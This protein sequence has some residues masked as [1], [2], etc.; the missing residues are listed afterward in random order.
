[1]IG[2]LTDIPGFQDVIVS[3]ALESHN[4]GIALEPVELWSFL[5]GLLRRA[6]LRSEHHVAAFLRNSHQD[7]GELFLKLLD[8][9]DG[10]WQ[11]LFRSHLQV[12]AKWLGSTTSYFRAPS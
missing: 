3:S 6:P 12:S 1:M 7:A 4:P 8:G 2:L 11:R 5:P 9:V 10:K